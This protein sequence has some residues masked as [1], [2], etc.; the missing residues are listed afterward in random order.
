[1]ERLWFLWNLNPD[2]AGY[3]I[4]GAVRLTGNLDVSAL[5]R[6]LTGL[7]QRHEVL[8][9]VYMEDGDGACQV[10]HD[11]PT[12]GW[13][14]VDLANSPSSEQE[15][16]AEG[17]RAPFDLRNGPVFRILLI[18]IRPDQHVL[19]FVMHHIASD[20]W[21]MT[22]LVRDFCELYAAETEQRPANLTPLTIQYADYALWQREWL[23]D[24]ALTD[25][26]AYW[27]DRLGGEQPVTTLPLDRPRR[28]PRDHR[29]G[30]VGIRLEEKT[31]T[32]L[33]QLSRHHGATLFM[34]LL[35]GFDLLLHR[36]GGDEDIRI[37]VPVAGRNRVETEGL[38]GFFVNTLVLRAD[39][40]GSMTVGDLIN[41]VRDRM[42]EAQSHQ[43][44]PFE[45]LVAAL[46]PVRDQSIS[47]L[48]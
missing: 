40:T 11:D 42:L 6:A 21:S 43:D 44:L 41:Q 30:S 19:Q 25:Q 29:G 10:I 23:D 22:I 3:N 15:L 45:R 48:F 4:A 12:F 28:A 46:Q 8:R 38:V 47:P 32:R 9:T 1:Q 37:G 18:Q 16:L 14:E 20:G 39:L 2:D 35:A 13:H 17:A 5:R 33:R 31:V 7:V 27:Q 34:T 26:L 36:Y 24:Q